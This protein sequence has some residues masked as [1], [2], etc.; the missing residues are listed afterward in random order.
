MAD[1][2]QPFRSNSSM[3]REVDEL[4]DDSMFTRRPGVRNETPGTST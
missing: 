2:E 3:E 4:L 1:K